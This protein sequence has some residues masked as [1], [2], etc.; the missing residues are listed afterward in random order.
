MEPCLASWDMKIQIILGSK[1]FHW[2]CLEIK[3]HC[4][5]RTF[6]V[7][8]DKYYC[9]Q[10]NSEIII[11]GRPAGFDPLCNVVFLVLENKFE[12]VEL[13]HGT[14]IGNRREGIGVKP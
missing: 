1:H 9:S 3:R 11:Q 4:F 2:S 10:W 14:K 7:Y 12:N 13:M 8:I 5:F 6:V